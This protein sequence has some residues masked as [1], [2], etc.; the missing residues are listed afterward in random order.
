MG[1]TVQTAPPVTVTNG[2]TLW[3]CGK[4]DMK[5]EGLELG[6]RVSI[7][8]VLLPEIQTMSIV[9]CFLDFGSQMTDLGT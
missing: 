4:Q 1:V 8:T 2:V 7:V 3:R 5:R 9:Q 6:K